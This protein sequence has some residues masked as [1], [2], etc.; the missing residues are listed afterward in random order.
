MTNETKV[1]V[2]M[3]VGQFKA[4]VRNLNLVWKGPGN[5]HLCRTD[6][7]HYEVENAESFDTD[8]QRASYIARLKLKI[9][10]Y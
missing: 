5:V 9:R 2:G 3:T 4:E 6:H 8:E 10:G 1:S 7:E